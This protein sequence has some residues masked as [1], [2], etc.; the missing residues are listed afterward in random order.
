[1]ARGIIDTIGTSLKYTTDPW[2][3][4]WDP[5]LNHVGQG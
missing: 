1:M 4:I 3:A 5:V 2:S